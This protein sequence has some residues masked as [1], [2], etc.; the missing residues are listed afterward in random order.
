MTV[1]LIATVC[2]LG[3]AGLLTL[4]RLAL[5]PTVGDRL[6]AL[7]TLVVIAVSGIAVTAALTGAGSAVIVLTVVALAGFLSTVAVVRFNEERT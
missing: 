1:V 2:L 6:V 7:D 4:V 3:V 5:G